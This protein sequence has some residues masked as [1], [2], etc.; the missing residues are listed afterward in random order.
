MARRKRSDKEFADLT[1]EI[2]VERFQ[3]SVKGGFVDFPDPRL[4][5]RCIYPAWYLFLVIL[6]GYLAGCNTIEDIAYFAELRA[7]WFAGLTGMKSVPSYDTLWW[8]LTRVKPEVFKTL[9]VKWF[10]RLDVDMRNRLLVIDGKRLC[11]ISDSDHITHIVELFAAEKRLVIAQEK[12][13]DKTSEREALPA[14]L[15]SIDVKGAI[16]T[17]DALYAHLADIE[18]VLRR[19]ADYIVG[20]KGNQ[21]TLE[22]EVSNFFEQAYSVGYDEVAVTRVKRAEKDHGRIEERTVCV[23]NDLDWLPQREKWHLQ[24]LVEVRAERIASGKM[25]KS[26]RY[27]GS[28]RKGNADQFMDWIRD[29]WSIESMHYV[30]DV[31][32][33]E[34]ASPGD[35]GYSAENMALIRRLAGN[36]IKVFDPKCGMTTA[37]RC[38]TY[39]PAYL[40]G[41]LAK[42]FVK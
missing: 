36:V 20:I 30:M 4:V 1:Q 19:G 8:F 9:L 16:V 5:S 42:V 23:T 35:S 40:R 7:A 21:G 38:A 18:E 11:G 37:R 29:H 26:I 22:A 31:V 13:P 24:S 6:S 2:D 39:E 34:D 12:V 33:E 10:Q 32:F 27:Y 17:M 41:L 15:D 28:S 25:E 14:L 3:A